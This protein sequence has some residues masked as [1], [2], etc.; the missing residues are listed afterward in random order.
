MISTFE[1]IMLLNVAS[2]RFFRDPRRC[3]VAPSVLT[4]YDSEHSRINNFTNMTNYDTPS[5]HPLSTAFVGPAVVLAE[6][7]YDPRS[8]P[9]DSRLPS[10]A[11]NRIEFVYKARKMLESQEISRVIHEWIDRV[12]G[13]LAP[14]GPFTTRV[15]LKEHPPRQTLPI[16]M[17]PVE[18]QL[19][20]G[21]SVQTSRL[22]RVKRD[23]ATFGVLT[24][25]RRFCSITLEYR[26]S[27]LACEC[28]PVASIDCRADDL[29]FSD[30]GHL[31]AFSQSESALFRIRD[32]AA[33]EKL[34]LF[35]ETPLIVPYGRRM[36]FCPDR[37]SVATLSIRDG[38][39]RAAT[40]C[41][42]PTPI[43]A[44]AADRHHQILAYATADDCLCIHD[45]HNG[46]VLARFS[47]GAPLSA[48]V[49]TG[50]WGFVLAFTRD[51]VFVFS[52]N[53]EFIKSERPQLHFARLFPHPSAA[54]FDFVSFVTHGGELGYF[55]A[56]FPGSPV[57]VSKVD[58][59]VAS[60]VPDEE[61]HT[62]MLFGTNGT[63]RVYPSWLT[64]WDAV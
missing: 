36:L 37:F 15:F 49:V 48:V 47:A 18:Y 50:C 41:H 23:A 3:P 59:A 28:V 11:G 5:I 9:K 40:V 13:C 14:L 19:K 38:R 6:L 21:L 53:G 10:W 29:V 63:L 61:H 64:Q 26:R 27:N 62:M 20:L 55:E 32:N 4:N 57:V 16:E 7:F 12:F 58:Y 52:V 1:Y 42:S 45:A 46:T 33:I 24:L 25:D 34:P 31:Y 35:A 2:G 22:F 39:P 54:G 44:L 17:V 8:I 51:Q 43:T 60:I 56:F 30:S